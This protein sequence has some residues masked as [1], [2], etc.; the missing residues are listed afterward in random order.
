MGLILIFDGEDFHRMPYP[1]KCFFPYDEG[2]T[3][4]ILGPVRHEWK[5]EPL[6]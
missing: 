4:Q 1:K 6:R 5:G 3:I 2:V